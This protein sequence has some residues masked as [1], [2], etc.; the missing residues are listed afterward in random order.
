[1]IE[2][3]GRLVIVYIEYNLPI[4]Q[5]GFYVSS[6]GTGNWSGEAGGTTDGN[7]SGGEVS[8]ST[9]VGLAPM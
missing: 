5:K 8:D 2:A 3:H 1:M 4:S 6:N 7:D 9:A